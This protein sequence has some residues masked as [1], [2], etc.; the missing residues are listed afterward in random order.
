M[1]YILILILLIVCMYA[2]TTNH[3][4]FIQTEEVVDS[5]FHVFDAF[6]DTE[7]NYILGLIDSKKYVDAK[8][9]IHDHPVVIKKLQTI[10]GEDY[11]FTDYIFSIEKSS[12]STC[13]R[14]ENGTVL[15]P[16]MKHPS[17]TIIFFL[18][19]MKSCLDVI[20]KSHK[21]RNKIY[22]TKSIK[23]VGCEP[24]QAVLFDANLIHSGAINA[25]NDNKRI[26]MKVTHREDLEN[27]GEFDKQYYR[28]GDA[29]KD[30][31]DK[32]T[33]FYRRMS[34]LL[35]GIS[36][37]TANGNNMPEFMKKL[38]KKLVY[39]GENKYELKVVEP[40]E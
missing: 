18:E 7:I 8:K 32:N 31:S 6:N 29:S 9:F 16:N 4:H 24:G 13:H 5:G 39:G 37:V 36:D 35:P 38:Y 17:Y 11:V 14:D 27:I 2:T 25:K 28:V 1:R 3:V 20:P 33:L 23:S 15:N 22:I 10:L 19:E 12:V 34:C 30:T 40:E 26:Q 21:E